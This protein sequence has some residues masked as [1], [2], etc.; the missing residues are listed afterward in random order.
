MTDSGIDAL[1]EAI[2]D[3]IADMAERVHAEV[4]AGRSLRAFIL[5]LRPDEA[6]DLAAFAAMLLEQ[7]WSATLATPEPQPTG[8]RRENQMSARIVNREHIDLM[9]R[10]VTEGPAGVPVSP[11]GAWYTSVSGLDADSI[12][13]MLIDTWVASVS[14]RYSEST[15]SLPGPVARYYLEPYAYAVPSHRL[16]VPEALKALDGYEYQSG[17]HPDWP[18]SPA[19]AL[20]DEMRGRLIARVPGYDAAPWTW[21]AADL[22]G[23]AS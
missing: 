11:D 10:L 7:R 13:Q 4:V 18:M 1:Q 5:A 14:Y 22:A 2:A 16:D 23:A 15:D 9:V 20:C 6:Y 19:K 21:D 12:G 8:A 3:R 17:E